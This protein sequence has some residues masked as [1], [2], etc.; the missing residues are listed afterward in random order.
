LN[1][2]ALAASILTRV[3]GEGRSLTAALESALP[4][5][6]SDQ[7]RA[8]VQSLCYGVLRGYERLEGLLGQLAPRPIKD[9]EIRMLALLG[10]HQLEYMRVKPH[11]AVAETVAAAGAK[12]WAKPL[13]NGIL[14]NYQ[15]Q[16][17]RLLSQADAIE[18]CRLNH[19]AWL[20]ER[21]RTDWPEQ[22]EALFA[23]GNRPPP[24]TLRVNR[25]KLTR[26][27]YLAR[28]ASAGLSARP[29]EHAPEAVVLE[30]P[31]AVERLPGFAGGLVSVQDEAAQLAAGLLDLRPGQRVLDVCAAPG[32][33]T[34][35]IL[36]T[37]PELAAVVALDIAD[38]R[39]DR[40]KQNLAREH[41]GATVLAGD[42]TAP[43]AWWDGR[44]FDRILLDAPC[45][46]TGVIRRHPDIK[47]LRR[48]QDIGALQDL[49]A[50]ILDA[51]WRLL[52]PGGELLY[53]TCSVLRAENEATMTRFLDTHPEARAL[54]IEARWGRSSGPGRQIL[55][56]ERGMDGFYYARLAR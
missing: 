28:L 37:C 39:I 9:F 32:G 26:D 2:R 6:P 29:G 22:A 47:R 18:S 30:S 4:E 13:L 3:V 1:S 45:S 54:A 52:A 17:E 44:P 34:L 40:L 56:G 43:D 36:E 27:E 19:P 48:P 50:R 11:A 15:R 35:H 55:T 5:L 20:I 21:I 49:Q 46:A 14:R 41:L 16:R 8:F 42:A 7:D 33:K 23:E 24:M 12:N 10:V 51:V 25:R 53:A 38:E 31:V